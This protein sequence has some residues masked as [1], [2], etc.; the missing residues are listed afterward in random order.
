[1]G[2]QYIIEC[3][4]CNNGFVW[5]EGAD[6]FFDVLHCDKCGRELWSSER[7]LEYENIKCLC[8][9]YFDKEV[10][11]ICPYCGNEI[12]NPRSHVLNA[13]AWGRNDTVGLESSQGSTEEGPCCAIK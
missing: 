1:M 9:G 4:H 5:N 6:S 2:Y 12:N 3:P 7:L 13:A 10:P 8:G 11:I